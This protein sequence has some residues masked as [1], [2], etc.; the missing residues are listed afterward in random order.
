MIDETLIPPDDL[1][2]DG[3]GTR[4]DFIEGGV[5]LLWNGLVARAGLKPDMAVLDIG[6][7]DGKHAQVLADFLSSEGK[8]RGQCHWREV[9]PGKLRQISQLR[10]QAR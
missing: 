7:G 1:L 2:S 10:I 5:G 6:S 3:P 8:Y 4:E 9:V